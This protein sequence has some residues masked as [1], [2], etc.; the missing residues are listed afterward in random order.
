MKAIVP[1]ETVQQR[2]CLIR[3]HKVMLDR[4]LAELYEVPTG[5][6][7]QAVRRNRKRFPPDFM[8]QLSRK[9]LENWKS[10]FVISNS[11]LKIGL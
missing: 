10:Q 6:L 4:G 8:F 9:E 7:N 3:G 1:V 11:R 5:A 2:I